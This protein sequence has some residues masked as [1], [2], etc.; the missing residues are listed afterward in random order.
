MQ[1]VIP[2]LYAFAKEQ[3]VINMKETN[4]WVAL[5]LFFVHGRLKIA[6]SLQFIMK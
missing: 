2:Y 4:W 1:E 6:N 3:D 5:K